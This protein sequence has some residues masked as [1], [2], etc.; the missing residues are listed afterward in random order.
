VK[1]SA[2]L[3]PAVIF[4]LLAGGC[5]KM[6]KPV[7]VEAEK[8]AIRRVIASN[9]GWAATKDTTLLYSTVAHDDDF[10]YFS[11]SDAGNIRGYKD[12]VN[13]TENFFLLDEFQAVDYQ[14]RDLYIGVSKS[15]EAAWFHTRLDDHNLWKGRPANWENA[16]WSGVLEKRDGRWVI[17]QM[18][19]SFATDAEK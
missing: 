2:F 3:L 12:F 11:P 7:N 4:I 15:G 6:T 19:F 8:A 18:H 5:Q 10:F 16:R 1:L 13:L 17:V 14:L 9:I